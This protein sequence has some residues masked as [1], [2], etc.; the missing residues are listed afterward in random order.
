MPLS[1]ILNYNMNRKQYRLEDL[2]A[3]IAVALG[4]ACSVG[5]IYRP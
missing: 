3:N 5:E 4:V 2:T 1:S